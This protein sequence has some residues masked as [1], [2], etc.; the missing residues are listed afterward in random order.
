MLNFI[1]GAPAS[2]KTYTIL[3]K[4]KELSESGRDSILIVPEQYNFP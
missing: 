1:L 3:N 4:I 2:G